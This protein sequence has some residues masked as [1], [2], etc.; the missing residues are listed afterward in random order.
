MISVMCRCGRKLK[1]P[2]ELAGRVAK[3][4]VCGALLDLPTSIDEPALLE[5]EPPVAPPQPWPNPMDAD[6]PGIKAAAGHATARPPAADAATMPPMN[7]VGLFSLMLSVVGSLASIALIFIASAAIY[8]ALVDRYGYRPSGLSLGPSGLS[9]GIAIFAIIPAAVDG[10]AL[11]VAN[12][13]DQR[14]VRKY[15]V[16][17]LCLA[18]VIPALAAVH[19]LVGMAT[20][21]SRGGGPADML[22]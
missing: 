20:T 6:E 14:V 19:L 5:A 21:A 7:V 17:S 1:A 13:G 9:L 8:S 11:L 15:A 2:D 12:L 4:P 18:A 3:C 10:F 16:W 22:R